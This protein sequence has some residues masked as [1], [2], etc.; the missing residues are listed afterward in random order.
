MTPSDLGLRYLLPRPLSQVG[1][2][3]PKYLMMRMR[4]MS[5]CHDLFCGSSPTQCFRHRLFYEASDQLPLLPLF[6]CKIAAHCNLLYPFGATSF[7][8]QSHYQE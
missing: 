6:G 7:G 5:D 4:M 2:H 1:I 3:H 8:K